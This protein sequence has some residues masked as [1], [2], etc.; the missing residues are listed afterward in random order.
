VCFPAFATLERCQ[1]LTFLYPSLRISP[2]IFFNLGE[3]DTSE[4]PIENPRCMPKYL[5]QSL[6]NRSKK[7]L[8]YSDP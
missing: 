4:M 2:L 8:A 1:V 3:G 7:L 6:E 5:E